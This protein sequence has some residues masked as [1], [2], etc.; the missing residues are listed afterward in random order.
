MPHDRKRR[1]HGNNR[2][3]GGSKT[4]KMKR[5]NLEESMDKKRFRVIE[6]EEWNLFFR[7]HPIRGG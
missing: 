2:A 4:A 7:G 3:Y 6:N 1:N 5:R